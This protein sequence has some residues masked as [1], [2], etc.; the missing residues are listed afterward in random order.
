M[1]QMKIFALLLFAALLALPMAMT[2][3]VEGQSP[4]EAPTGFDNQTNGF[5]N[6]ATFD[7]DKRTFE[8]RDE[9][10]P[11]ANQG[12]GLGPVYNAQACAECHQN[13][14]SGGISQIT[15]L[16]AG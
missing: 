3:T 15:E 2:G 4:T 11:D 12:G 7:A 1:K 5:T 13:P 14:V 16:R 6:Q 8:E 9:I 10:L